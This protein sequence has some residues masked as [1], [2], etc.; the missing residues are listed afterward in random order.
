MT[1][2]THTTS[3]I[4]RE[5]AGVGEEPDEQKRVRLIGR[6]VKIKGVGKSGFGILQDEHDYIQYY[7]HRDNVGGDVYRE[8]RGCAIGS[9]IAIEGV[10]YRTPNLNTITIRTDTFEILAALDYRDHIIFTRSDTRPNPP[11]DV[12]WNEDETFEY[13]T[14][15]E[16]TWIRGIP[17]GG[18]TLWGQVVIFDRSV[19]G[20]RIDGE[21]FT[22]ADMPSNRGPG[23]NKDGS[24][25]AD[26]R[27][28]ASG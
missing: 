26:R 10:V 1:D 5:F 19:N 3:G 20:M 18:E 14:D 2:A 12:I 11:T 7:V 28:S 4:Y 27:N 15:D 25:S 17:A 16:T 6:A 8:F 23:E 24:D 21:M 22:A 13:L 9:L